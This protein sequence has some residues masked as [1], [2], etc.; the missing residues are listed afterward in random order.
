MLRLQRGWKGERRCLISMS[1][2]MSIMGAGMN[3]FMSLIM[4]MERSTN[5]VMTIITAAGSK[6]ENG[7]D[8]R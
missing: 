8:E 4:S 6:Q 5:I 2:Y 3:M 1:M 7:K